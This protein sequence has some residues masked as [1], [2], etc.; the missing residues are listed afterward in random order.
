[1]RISNRKSYQFV[2]LL[3]RSR[4]SMAIT[5]YQVRSEQNPVFFSQVPIRLCSSRSHAD[6]APHD[7]PDLRPFRIGWEGMQHRRESRSSAFSTKRA[8][9]L[10]S[11]TSSQTQTSP[12]LVRASSRDS[13]RLHLHFCI[14]R[15]VFGHSDIS[16]IIEPSIHDT[17]GILLLFEFPTLGMTR[18]AIVQSFTTLIHPSR[19]VFPKRLLDR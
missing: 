16:I 17:R 13:Q 9:H 8:C 6:S 1:M 15:K 10:N 14:L 18:W 2:C 3:F 11:R 4:T 7:T 19:H 5:R 12:R